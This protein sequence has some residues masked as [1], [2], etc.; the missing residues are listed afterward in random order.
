M[1]YRNLSVLCATFP[2]VPVVAMT[3]TASKSDRETIKNLLGLKQC[4]EVVGN[5]DRTNITYEKH[6]ELDQMWIV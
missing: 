2:K 6:F 5:P 3:A 1:D 4:N